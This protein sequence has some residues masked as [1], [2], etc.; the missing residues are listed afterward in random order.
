MSNQSNSSSAAGGGGGPAGGVPAGGVP[1]NIN[2]LIAKLSKA[3]ENRETTNAQDLV[4]E[5]LRIDFKETTDENATEAIKRLKTINTNLNSSIM[6]DIVNVIP[7]IEKIVRDRPTLASLAMRLN[8][9]TQRLT[10]AIVNQTGDERYGLTDIENTTNALEQTTREQEELLNVYKQMAEARRAQN[11]ER[12]NKLVKEAE[13]RE[14]AIREALRARTEEDYESE[15]QKVLSGKVPMAKVIEKYD[16]KQAAIMEEGKKNE[17]W[18]G[19]VERVYNTQIKPYAEKWRQNIPS[20]KGVARTGAGLAMLRPA[21][22]GI[23]TMMG[24]GSALESSAIAGSGVAGS[25]VAGSGVAGSGVVSTPG[26]FAR[27]F[28]S[29]AFRGSLQAGSVIGLAALLALYGP[30][31][32]RWTQGVYETLSDQLG[33]LSNYIA[34]IWRPQRENLSLLSGISNHG[35]TEYNAYTPADYQQMTANLNAALTPAQREELRRVADTPL[36]PDIETGLAGGTLTGITGRQLLDAAANNNQ[37]AQ[38]VVAGALN[39]IGSRAPSLAN[40]PAGSQNEGFGLGGRRKR[41]STKK[42]PIRRRRGTKRRGT[43]KRQRRYT[44]RRRGLRRR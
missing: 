44:K 24:M 2:D 6:R 14:R 35:P 31:A 8:I 25:G 12:F 1:K 33:D 39:D 11:R 30:D 16:E 37:Q 40:T 36:P 43:R 10:S 18:M 34:G 19:F 23:G 5:L 3:V 26:A 13:A 22:Q 42:R 32:F 28:A 17:D 29:A 21:A 41:R 38:A 9:Q 20:Q 7:V 27:L 15:V 4:E